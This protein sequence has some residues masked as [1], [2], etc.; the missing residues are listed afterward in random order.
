MKVFY[1][2]NDLGCHKRLV[3][4]PSNG[5]GVYTTTIWNMENGEMCGVGKATAQ[6]LKDFLAHYGQIFE[7]K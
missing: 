7:E 5:D 4:R 1:Y 6:E 3:V 2:V